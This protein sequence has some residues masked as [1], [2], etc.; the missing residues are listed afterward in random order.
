MFEA[1]FQ[2]VGFG[3]MTFGSATESL[4]GERSSLP[5]CLILDDRGR[6]IVP[7]CLD[8]HYGSRLIFGGSILSA[9]VR[10]MAAA[11]AVLPDRTINPIAA[12]IIAP[13]TN[14]G[15]APVAISLCAR[16]SNSRAISALSRCLVIVGL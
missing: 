15:L 13:D 16:L 10:S 8:S 3:V 11:L 12:Q 4:R 9:T 6:R 2:S 1:L 7:G 14:I 5:S